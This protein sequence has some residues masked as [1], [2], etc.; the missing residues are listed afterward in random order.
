MLVHLIILFIKCAV[1]GYDGSNAETAKG[2]LRGRNSRTFLP[3]I[4]CLP[5]KL[6]VAFSK[7]TEMDKEHVAKQN[8]EEPY[9][10]H[11]DHALSHKVFPLLLNRLMPIPTAPLPN[12]LDAASQT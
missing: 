11:N 6:S 3:A 10:S 8:A 12:S 5:P 4:H 1:V 2:T 9:N 7:E